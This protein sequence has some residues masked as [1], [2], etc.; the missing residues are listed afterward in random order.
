MTNDK[1]RS[2]IDECKWDSKLWRHSLTTLEFSTT[3]IEN[4]DSTGITLDDPNKF[5]VQATAGQASSSKDKRI[6]P[7]H[8]GDTQLSKQK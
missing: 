2:T 6:G 7:H 1:T 5:I 3:L 8:A 4:I